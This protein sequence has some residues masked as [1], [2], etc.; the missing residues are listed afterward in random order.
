MAQRS[1]ITVFVVLVALAGAIGIGLYFT[2]QQ[3]QTGASSSRGN[4]Q[5]T[6]MSKLVNQQPLQTA[7]Q[8]DKL[9]NTR[10]EARYSRDALRIAD[11]E[12]DLAFASALRNAR[13]HPAAETP[14][15]KKIH[16][17][18]SQLEAEV[19]SDQEQVNRLKAAQ[20]AA[21]GV[22]A[23][24][25]SDRQQLAAA[26]L[27][28]RQDELADAKLDLMRAGG[29]NESRIQR[30]FAQHETSQHP[31]QPQPF[32][33]REPFQIPG[34]MVAQVRLMMQ[35]HE[36][37]L[38]V[39][40]AAQAS[41]D[42]AKELDAKHEELE[43]NL[44]SSA[45]L[46]PQPAN[47]VTLAALQRQSEERKLVTQYDQRVQD[48][49]QL[50]KTY[51]DWANLLHGR[52]LASL[53][54]VLLGVL[55][56]VVIVALIVSGNIAVDHLAKRISLDRRKMATTRLLG[57][58][59]VQGLGIL[60]IGFVLIG[61]PSNLSTVIALAGAG[62]T[63]ALKDFIVAFF[64]WF[65]LMGKNGIRVGDWVEINGIGGEVAE[66]GL[67]RTVLLETGNWADSGH[68]TGRRVT[69]VNSFAIEGHYFNFSTSGQWLWDTLE[70]NIPSGTDPY[71]LTDSLL[72]LVKKQSEENTREAEKEW[73]RATH[74][75][76]QAFTAE[77]AL[78]LR[79][80][81]QGTTVIVRYITRANE[82][83]ATRTQLYQQVVEMLHSKKTSGLQRG[84]SA[85]E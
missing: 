30:L 29:D 76:M 15:T 71:F 33:L 19:A 42:A 9:A 46:E 45:P 75:H 49:Q 77:P 85:T 79:P 36:K 39:L 34:S 74:D 53:H 47:A 40:D 64:G 17:R 31:D 48:H 69:F 61:P 28:L 62:L 58:F 10:E 14:D 65:V 82:R 41:Q 8:L 44:A 63:V 67:L 43:K 25:L 56:I 22:A 50:E 54:S 6:P 57:H 24:D 68:P 12:V 4:R 32:Q 1:R 80:S 20:S 2:A 78:S 27:A 18:I 72:A 7:Q 16:E 11:H 13:L 81:Q 70:I 51:A 52:I 35:L 73:R 5:I 60:F 55:W 37:R 3:D 84:S 38:H 23:E 59:V 21:R 66:I 26:E 83:Y